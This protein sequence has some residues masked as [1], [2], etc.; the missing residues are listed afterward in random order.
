M[1]TLQDECTF[2]SS[3][4]TLFKFAPITSCDVERSFS[5]YKNVLSDH[6][7]SFKPDALKMNLVVH[8]N[9]TRGAE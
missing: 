7:R 3:D 4:L 8:F 5:F 1:S 9:S 2:D 6:R